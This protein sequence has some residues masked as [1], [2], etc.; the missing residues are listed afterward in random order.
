VEKRA[1]LAFGLSIALLVAYLWIMQTYFEPPARPTPSP[2]AEAPTPPAEPAAP[3]PARPGPAAAPPRVEVPIRAA[4][5]PRPPQTTATLTAPLYRGVV[6]SEGGKFQEWTLHYRGDKPMVLVG[7]Q[8]PLG[9]L[10]GQDAA[11]AQV[12]PLTLRPDSLVLDAGRATGEL[13]LTAETQGLRVRQALR[14]H[15]AG[16]AV[17]VFL[18]VENPSGAARTVTLILPWVYRHLE[19]P[20]PEKF[21]GQRPHE[22]VWA[23]RGGVERVE[24]LAGLGSREIE[25][26]WIAIGST[27]YLAAVVPQTS[28]FTLVTSSEAKKD[29]AKNGEYRVMI[30]ARAAP[31]IGPGRSWE[32]HVV[33]YVGPKE[34]DRLEA[35]GLTG[36]VN[37]GGFPIPQRYGG[38][39]MEWLGVPILKLMNWLHRY[40]PNYGVVIIL[41]TVISKVLFYPLTV[42]SVRSMKAMQTLQ[43]QVNS[44]RAKYKNDPR[45]LQEETLA[46]YRRQGVNPMGG[47]LPMVAQVPIFYALYLALSVSVELQNAP[48][49]CFGRAFGVDL[50]ICDLANYD[51]TYV[52]PIFMGISMFVQQ[53]MTPTTGDPRQAKMMLVMPFIFT[54]MFLQL[55]SGLVL[56]WFVSNVLQILQQW[57][58]DR[59]RGLRAAKETARG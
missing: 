25:G 46:L 39:P 20:P 38:L 44:L 33:L 11:S 54:F 18:R 36:T 13:E 7:E 5:G 1:V 41:L 4:E 49:L 58:M 15:A 45:K 17:D 8:G 50:W 16:Y 19:K 26:D 10:V 28:G 32:G 48:F 37:F 22:V 47:C 59:P 9:L 3:S 43:P 51:P 42:K 6:S 14:F 56:Y 24:D 27:W 34:Y 31:T 35:L 23:T 30:A 55:P 52:L 2:Q 29:G 53:K 57:W 12:L 21:A 40:L